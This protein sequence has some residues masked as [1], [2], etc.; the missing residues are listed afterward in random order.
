MYTLHMIKQKRISLERLSEMLTDWLGTTSSILIHTLFFIGMFLTLFF[1]WSLN[2]MLLVLTTVV[3]IEAIYLALFI[4]M[5][6]NKT[7]KN[8]ED[9][10]DDIEIIQKS[11][12]QDDIQDERIEKTLLTINERIN[13]IQNDLEV[14]RK[15]NHPIK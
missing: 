5:T 8:I 15:L 3:S 11:D 7:T 6:V 13:R 4:Q 12:K 14:L 1:G 9:V 10:E 2:R